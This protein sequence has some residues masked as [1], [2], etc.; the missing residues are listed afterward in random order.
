MHDIEPFYRWRN[1]YT[2]EEDERSPFYGRVYSE[3][4]FSNR[5]Y[6]YFIH[7]QWDD[8]GSETLYAKILFADYEEGYAILEFIG[9]WNDCIHN[10]I[11]SLKQEILNTLT[12]Q[13]ITRFIFIVENVLN[14]HGDCTDYYEEWL[15][16][17]NEE[18]GWVC[19]L[20]V[21]QHV[22]EEMEATQLHHYVHFGEL[23]NELR[24]RPRKP[25][26]VLF[27][28]ERRLHGEWQLLE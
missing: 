1:L 27:E 20:N 22:R 12:Q 18:Q 13:G 28:V 17:L 8:F 3:F 2:A 9:E 24:W 25:E 14:F 19:M 16:E 26:F 10:D 6:N 4:T 21:R 7:P 11:L 23:F 15:E 5:I